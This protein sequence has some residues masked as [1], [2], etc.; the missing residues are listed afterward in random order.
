MAAAAATVTA[1]PLREAVAALP[2][3]EESRDGYQREKFRHWIDADGDGCN[4]RAEVLIDEAVIA[5]EVGPK[6]VLAG[7]RWY[8]SYD[9]EY[10]SDARALDIDH[11]VPLAEAWDSGA[12]A[13]AAA[14][15]EAYA[16]DLHEPRALAAVTAR[17]NRSKGDQDPSTWFPPYAAAHCGYITDWVIVKTRWG[18]TVDRNEKAVLTDKAASCPNVPITVDIA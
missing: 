16:N 2:V 15:R 14:R 6:C 5:P 9:D 8:S 4:T 10:V 13:W 11:V 17:S 12:S 3:A 18:L 1:V 7:G